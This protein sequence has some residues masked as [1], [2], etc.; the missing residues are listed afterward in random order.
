ME[1][2]I[3][4]RTQIKISEIS[5]GSWAIGG[6]MWG[7]Q[8]DGVSLNALRRALD[9]GVNFVDTAAIY[10]NGHSE[11]LVGKI[12]AERNRA[13]SIATKIPPKNGRW[14]AQHGSPAR[15]IFHPQWIRTHTEKSLR[16]LNVDCIDLQQLHVWAPNW[17]KENDWFLEMRRLKEEG[18]IRYIGVSLNDHEPDD[19]VELVKSGMV[20]SVQVI[21]NIFDQS[22]QDKLFP[23]CQE[24]NVGVLARVPLDEGSLTGK[25]TKDSK[26]APNDWRK[27]YFSPSRLKETLSR[28]EQLKFL[29]RDGIPSLT[30][31]ALKFCISHPAVSAV[32]PGIRSVEQAEQNCSAS[33]GNL[34]EPQ[35]LEQLKTHRWIHK[36]P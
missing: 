23:A 2:R 7:P 35:I 29:L 19:A 13:F 6:D 36:Y 5:F 12:H 26:F 15:E 32:I 3:L 20:D 24:S 28:V 1:Y 18:K 16:N 11:I 27:N 30:T 9:L 21:Y 8:D 10:G 34:L 31:P 4:G 22:P 17:V 14:P 33:D 25:F